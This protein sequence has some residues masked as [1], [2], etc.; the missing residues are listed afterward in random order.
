MKRI[1]L[2]S[3]IIVF[4]LIDQ[5]AQQNTGSLGGQLGQTAAKDSEWSGTFSG[6]IN[7]TNSVL[8]LD[9]KLGSLK[10]E[11]NADGYI[12]EL[13]GKI[14]GS[15]SEGTLSDKTTGGSVAFKANLQNGSKI[16]LILFLSN[17]YGQAVEVPLQFS[18]AEGKA[19]AAVTA[20]VP[21]AESNVELDPHLIGAWRH[22][23][24]Y[25]SG[26]FGTVS[27]WY[28]NINAD[29]TYIY[30]DGVIAGGDEN[31]SFYSGGDSGNTKGKWKSKQGIVY[32]NNG[33]GWEAY[34]KYYV[35]GMS[36]LFTLS[37]GSK[38]LWEK[39]R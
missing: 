19:L 2:A 22:T 3:I 32:I 34:A 8:T 31:S 14:S 6:S 36:M 1:V 27:E 11:I 25:T 15:N 17:E 7:G 18:R 29:G 28:M 4:A 37:D 10:G 12:Y 23:E 38:Q 21:A 9:E 35:E 20:P 33:Y 39:Y 24:T 5:I 16:E 30:G 26:E 13:S